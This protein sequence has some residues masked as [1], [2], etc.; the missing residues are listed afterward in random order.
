MLFEIGYE[1]KYDYWKDSYGQGSWRED[2]RSN[3]FL[4]WDGTEPFEDMIRRNEQEFVASA[5]AVTHSDRNHR[6]EITCMRIGGEKSKVI[7]PIEKQT[8]QLFIEA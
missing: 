2:T 7:V 8:I 4:P 1:L 5:E 6:I 3:L